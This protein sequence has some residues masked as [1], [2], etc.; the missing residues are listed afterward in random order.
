MQKHAKMGMYK[1]KAVWPIQTRFQCGT[2]KKAYTEP[3]VQRK[4]L[5]D[6][7]ILMNHRWLGLWLNRS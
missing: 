3:R 2:G 6:L 5:N 7:T 4:S 1:L